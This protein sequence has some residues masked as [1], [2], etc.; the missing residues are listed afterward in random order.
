MSLARIDHN[1]QKINSCIVTQVRM[2]CTAKVTAD[3]AMPSQ[4]TGYGHIDGFGTIKFCK[5]AFAQKNHDTTDDCG[6]L[7]LDLQCF[8]GVGELCGISKFSCCVCTQMVLDTVEH[9]PLYQN[10]TKGRF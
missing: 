10:D 7:D 6:M 1:D 5:Q 3:D 4:V 2:A 8:A 9:S